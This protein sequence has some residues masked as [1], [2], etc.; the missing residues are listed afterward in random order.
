MTSNYGNNPS[1]P[2]TFCACSKSSISCPPSGRQNPRLLKAAGGGAAQRYAMH[3]SRLNGSQAPKDKNPQRWRPPLSAAQLL[4]GTEPQR[5]RETPRHRNP[6]PKGRGNLPETRT[7]EQKGLIEVGE[8]KT[9]KNPLLACTSHDQMAVPEKTSGY[10]HARLIRSKK[11]RTEHFGVLGLGYHSPSFGPRWV[12][13]LT[14]SRNTLE[15]SSISLA[16]PNERP[17]T[18]THTHTPFVFSSRQEA[19]RKYLEQKTGPPLPKR[20]AVQRRAETRRAFFLGL[21]AN[22]DDSRRIPAVVRGRLLSLDKQSLRH[23][24]RRKPGGARGVFPLLDNLF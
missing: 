11:T 24:Q 3:V 20:D 10:T 8:N 23:H 2:G 7:N 22:P 6:M 13:I 21:G 16:R 17:T 14:R 4:N 18:H 9:P 1:V 19:T 12:L 5:P 15:Q